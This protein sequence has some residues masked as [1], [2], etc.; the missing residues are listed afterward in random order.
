[1]VT[2]TINLDIKNFTINKTKETQQ[3]ILAFG[4]TTETAVDCLIC[5][6]A[7]SHFHGFDEPKQVRHLSV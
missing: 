6:T 2:L 5:G 3:V 7:T 4:K 1:M